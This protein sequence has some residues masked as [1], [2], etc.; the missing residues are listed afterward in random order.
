M[1]ALKLYLVFTRAAEFLFEQPAESAGEA[2]REAQAR[3]PRAATAYLKTEE[4]AHE[5]VFIHRAP[6]FTIG[7]VWT[8]LT[9]TTRSFAPRKGARRG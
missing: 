9:K 4:N 6:L 7:Q 3:D 5:A 2:L 8:P 1:I